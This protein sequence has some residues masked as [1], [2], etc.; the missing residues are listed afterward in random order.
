VVARPTTSA[1][2]DL[3]GTVWYYTYSVDTTS[4]PGHQRVFLVRPGYDDEGVI[5]I[6]RE[7]PGSWWMVGNEPNDPYQ[8]NLSPGAYAGFFHRFVE[9]ARAT[10][11]H[12]R[13]ASAG[14]ANA[15]WEWANAFREQYLAQYG[16]YPQLNAWNIHNYILE[17]E[18]DQLDREEFRRRILS[19]R[20][21]MGS[22]GDAGKPLFL[23]EFGAL[24]GLGNLGRRE[25]DP[26]RICDYM[27][28]IIRWLESTDH[29]Q[30]WSW[31]AN[32]T[33]GQFNGDLFDSSG[34]LTIFGTTYASAITTSV[35]QGAALDPS[36][37]A[38]ARPGGR[39]YVPASTSSGLE[40]S[41]TSPRAA[42][43]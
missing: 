4:I 42:R 23:S 32:D 30:W 8:D 6:L 13:I 19:F 14:I 3:L 41:A 7:N 34:S 2:L 24:F 16:R 36:R 9:M 12:A 27:R 21:W 28:D 31:F 18:L 33:G 43:N 26:V 25:E 37:E 17:P 11:A 39:S 22:I 35:V 38:V 40:V 20:D 1:A 29:V 5:Q 15:D 10:D